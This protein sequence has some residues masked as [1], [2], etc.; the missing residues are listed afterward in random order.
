MA[1]NKINLIRKEI[2]AWHKKGKKNLPWRKTDDLF[3]ILISEI[4]LQQTNTSSVKRI[5]DDFFNKYNNFEEIYKSN[6]KT[7]REDIKSLGLSNKRAKTLKRLSKKIIKTNNG[8]FPLKR[9]FLE[10]IKGIGQYISNA[11][12]CFGLNERTI[13]YD[14]N[15]KRIIERVFKKKNSS[16]QKAF[17]SERLEELVPQNGFKTFYYAL[18]DFGSKICLKTEPKCEICPISAYC[19]YF[20]NK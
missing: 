4:F 13:F 3:K 6:E 12:Q 8:K 19:D 11:Y 18:L 2:R 1:K 5:Y 15:I 17:I 9:E 20:I 16:S 14:V 10:N 7:L